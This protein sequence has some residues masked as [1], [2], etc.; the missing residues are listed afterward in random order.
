MNEV[1]QVEDLPPLPDE[2]DSIADDLDGDEADQARNVAEL[3]QKIYLGVGVVLTPDEARRIANKAGAGLAPG[4]D[5]R[6]ARPPA[7][8]GQP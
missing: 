5:P 2:D 4:V 7:Q 3:I 1:R 8:D 6:P